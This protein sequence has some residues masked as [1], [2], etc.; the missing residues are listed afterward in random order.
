MLISGKYLGWPLAMENNG[1][2]RCEKWRSPTAGI[3]VR[4][5]GGRPVPVVFKFL[6]NHRKPVHVQKLWPCGGPH[7]QCNWTRGPAAVATDQFGHQPIS[8]KLLASTNWVSRS[9]C[10]NVYA[11][12][13][14]VPK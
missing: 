10:S 4:S 6:R 12:L 9:S 2:V 11:S 8:K 3:D 1:P 5:M 13:V 7:Q 14:D